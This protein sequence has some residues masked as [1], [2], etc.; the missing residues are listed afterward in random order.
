MY[1]MA[2][3]PGTRN[4]SMNADSYTTTSSALRMYKM[5]VSSMIY[6]NLLMIVLQQRYHLETPPR[7]D[8]N[9]SYGWLDGII[10]LNKEINYLII[11]G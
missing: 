2:R 11:G 9:H 5:Q 6:A 10:N 8:L 1:Q 4:S 7:R 3:D